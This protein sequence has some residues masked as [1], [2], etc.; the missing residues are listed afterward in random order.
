[1]VSARA[2]PLAYQGAIWTE[3]W[4]PAAY[5]PRLQPPPGGRPATEEAL[6]RATPQ[7]RALGKPPARE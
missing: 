5:R 1:V 2:M 7:G 3:H 4:L 6:L